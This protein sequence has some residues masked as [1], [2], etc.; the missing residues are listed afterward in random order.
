VIKDRPADF[1]K[2][3]W[4]QLRDAALALPGSDGTDEDVLTHAMFP[5]VA[6]KFFETRAQGPKNVGKDPATVAAP[7]QAAA[8]VPKAD[9]G[10]GPVTTTIT[11]D[12]KLNGK[13]HRLT[14]S[15]AA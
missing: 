6:T 15:P 11:Y 8:A 2:P 7:A 3:E 13:S 9:A 12:V 1:L 4:D 5:Q 14:V 10:K